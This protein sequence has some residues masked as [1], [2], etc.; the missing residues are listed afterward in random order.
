MGGA[1]HVRKGGRQTPIYGQRTFTEMMGDG[2]VQ[3]PHVPRIVRPPVGGTAGAGGAGGGGDGEL[4]VEED[5]AED[6][7]ERRKGDARVTAAVA[8]AEGVHGGASGGGGPMGSGGEGAQAR[9]LGEEETL[10]PG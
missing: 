1:R 4:E 7:L 2:G 8:A 5:E 10:W 6:E 3:G 9:R